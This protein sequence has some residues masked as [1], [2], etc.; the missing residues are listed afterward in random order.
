MTAASLI[1]ALVRAKRFIPFVTGQAEDA[2]DY[3]S[4]FIAADELGAFVHKYDDEMMAVLQA[5]YDPTPYGHE[6]RGGE[7]RIKI[8]KPQLSILCGTTPSHL[9]RFLPEGAWNEGFLSRSILVF[10]DERIIGDDFALST[11]NKSQDLLHDLKIINS[12]TGEWRVTE[13]YQKLVNLWRQQ[14]ER[15]VPD[16]P[17]LIHYNSRRRVNLYKL[18]MIS[19]ID[20]TNAPVISRDDFNR[21]IGWLHEAELYMP[22]IFKASGT[23]ADSQAIDEIYHYVLSMDLKRDGVPE[24]KVVNFA[25]ERVPANSVL[26]V[27]EVMERSGLLEVSTSGPRSWRAIVKG[28]D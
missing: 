18:S 21:A 22:E 2:L 8:K 20:K 24:H 11:V 15:P 28:P 10:S 17:K 26:R 9:L 1:D 3:N 25:R 7:V 19:A 23:G 14:D 5:F 27:L 4:M 16:H 12:L 13:D 6:R